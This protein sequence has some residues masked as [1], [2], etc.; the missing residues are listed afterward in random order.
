MDV[1]HRLVVDMV[2]LTS[3]SASSSSSAHIR[4][5]TAV[6]PINTVTVGR[7]LCDVSST[8]GPT[9]SRCFSPPRGRIL[10][11]KTRQRVWPKRQSSACVTE[12]MNLSPVPLYN[13]AP[14]LQTRG[15]AI[16][17]NCGV[18]APG[19]LFPVPPW[20]TPMVPHI[21]PTFFHFTFLLDLPGIECLNVTSDVDYCSAVGIS[22]FS[23]WLRPGGPRGSN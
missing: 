11:T 20:F 10:P 8:N 7:C 16:R 6:G 3:S 13:P 18:V 9:V 5:L 12:T 17:Y 23:P 2:I 15:P 19:G 21:F 1:R 4:S 14:H 22:E